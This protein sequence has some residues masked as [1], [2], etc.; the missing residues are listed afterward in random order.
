[1][2][3]RD[4]VYRIILL[5]FIRY[6]SKCFIQYILF[7]LIL[8]HGRNNDVSSNL[9]YRIFE[10]QWGG[11]DIQTYLWLEYSINSQIFISIM[12]RRIL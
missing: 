12:K 6:S 10:K 7:D 2:T 1:M 4:I 11:N 8:R 3:F 9:R 5:Q